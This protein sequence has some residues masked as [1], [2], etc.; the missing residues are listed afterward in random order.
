MPSAK[1]PPAPAPWCLAP[2]GQTLVIGDHRGVITVRDANTG[3]EP[4][5]HKP[6]SGGVSGVAVSHDGA[7]L[8]SAGHDGT[9]KIWRADGL[10]QHKL[11][12]GHTDKV[13]AVAFFHHGLSLVTGSQD[14]SAKIWDVNTGKEKFALEGHQAAIEAVAVSPDDRLVATASWDKTVRLWDA[15]TGQEIAAFEGEK[16]QAFYAVAFSPDGKL[17]AGA[18]R[19]GTISLWDLLTREAAGTLEKHTA[20]IWS[21]AFSRDGILAS[22]SADRTAKLWHLGTGKRPRDLMTSWSGTRPILAV[23]YAP[24]ASVLAVATTDKT[25]HIRDAKS[26]DVIT[27][28]A[29]TPG[30]SQLPGVFTR[31]PEPGERQR[32]SYRQALG[33]VRGSR[34]DHLGGSWRRRP[35]PG[36]HAGWHAT[37]QRRR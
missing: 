3:D 7:F 28:L 5:R 8:A 25:I 12:Q 17:L 1:F 34:D 26:G 23:A 32:R 10:L 9:A 6:H 24:D 33:L 27:D 13:L 37:H 4:R 2:N 16:G 22:G 18:G 19:D 30:S 11:L 14:N 20:P 36:F 29:R 21:L 35:R 15:E 31:R